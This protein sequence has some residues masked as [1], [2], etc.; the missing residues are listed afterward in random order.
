MVK[1][2]YMTKMTWTGWVPFLCAW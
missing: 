1:M 2:A